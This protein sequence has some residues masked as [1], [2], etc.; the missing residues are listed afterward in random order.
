METDVNGHL[1][2]RLGKDVLTS[3]PALYRSG[4]I[5]GGWRFLQFEVEVGKLVEGKNTVGFRITRE[6][7]L[8]G[9]M[10]DYII[11]EWQN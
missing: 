10:W 3:D 9:F 7:K 5:S 8:R 2:G 11:L 6:T 4:R 1:L